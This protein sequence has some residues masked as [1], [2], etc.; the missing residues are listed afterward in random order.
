MTA[1]APLWLRLCAALAVAAL[2]ACAGRGDTVGPGHVGVERF[3][4]ELQ[5]RWTQIRAGR[6]PEVAVHQLTRN[7][8]LLDRLFVGALTDGQGLLTPGFDDYPRW[9]AGTPA[10]ALDAFLTDSLTEL[11]YT[12]VEVVSRTA[13]PFAGGP[14]VRY[15]LALEHPGGLEITGLA[16]AATRDGGLDLMLFLASAEHYFP[17][18]Q[19][20]VE[21]M[22]DSVIRR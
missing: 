20:E 15:T 14:G 13:Y 2:S 16:L 1:S 12:R 11:G 4:F 3:G 6:D 19:G 18:L 21:R 22:F 17:A 9:W 10:D 7:G 8:P 5:T